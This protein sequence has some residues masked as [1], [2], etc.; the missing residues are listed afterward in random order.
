M[1]LFFTSDQHFHHK[2]IIRLC[3]RPFADIDEMNAE[4]VRRHNE[5]VG[6][7]DTV[8]H[9]GDFAFAGVTRTAEVLAQLHGHHR[10]IKGNHDDRRVRLFRAG[11]E[12]VDYGPMELSIGGVVVTLSHYPYVYPDS[13]PHD[14]E[15]EH[16]AAT[17]EGGVLVHGH[18]H[19]RWARKGRMINVGVDVRGF[20]P[21]SED[22][23]V[24]EI[25]AALAE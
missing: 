24:A 11:F 12:T 2:N 14:A 21:M 9:L 3:S 4:L 10:L 17:D 19:T 15:F 8:W 23:L 18:V 13:D 16:R 20:A 25:H 7:D 22:E 6:P 5:R 1:A